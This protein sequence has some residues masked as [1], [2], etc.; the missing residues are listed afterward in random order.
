M[1]LL[2]ESKSTNIMW[3][4]LGVFV[5]ILVLLVILLALPFLV[6]RLRRNPSIARLFDK[7]ARLVGAP[8]DTI[9]VATHL[10]PISRSTLKGLAVTQYKKS[11]DPVTDPESQEAECCPICFCE[12]AAGQ[13]IMTLPCS[14]FFHKDCI[15]RWLKRDATCPICKMNL[16][17]SK[18][19]SKPASNVN[20]VNSLGAAHGAAAAPPAPVPV[21]TAAAQQQAGHASLTAAYAGSIMLVPV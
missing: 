9:H 19:C 3:A 10:R 1:S 14:H 20:N 6:S 15:K 17:P 12:Y 13:Q 18:H 11:A 5:S 2:F 4:P 16:E 8:E 7:L 21:Q